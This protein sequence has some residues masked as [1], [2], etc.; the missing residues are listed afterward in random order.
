CSIHTADSAPEAA[1]R[2][3]IA[4]NLRFAAERE[5]GEDLTEERRE[6]ERVPAATRPDDDR[7]GAVEH[8]VFVRRHLVQARFALHGRRLEPGEPAPHVVGRSVDRAWIGL[9]RALA[10]RHPRPTPALG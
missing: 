2:E 6:L 10:W 3:A 5:V 4:R 9:E 1:H 8:E 7:P